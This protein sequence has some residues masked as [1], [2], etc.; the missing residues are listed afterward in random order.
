MKTSLKSFTPTK[1]PAHRTRSFT[2]HGPGERGRQTQARK[3]FTL[4]ELLVVV[5]IVSILA[6]MLLPA[7]TKVRELGRRTVC[8]HKLKQIG[9]A[10]HLYANDHDDWINPGNMI[11]PQYWDGVRSD[12]NWHERFARIG[13]FS[14]LD[15]K[16]TYTQDIAGRV[17]FLCPSEK[18]VFTYH[19][20]ANNLWVT[21]YESFSSTF[22]L[23]KFS[24][25]TAN[26]TDVILVTEGER[27]GQVSATAVSLGHV[28]FRHNGLANTLYAD[29][30]VVVKK[31]IEIT[32][33]D[34]QVGK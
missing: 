17:S 7:L 26:P 27:T 4:I 1:R 25:L 31:Q 18:R 5:A 29:G 33:A 11:G 3:G 28:A 15:Y 30:R 22:P 9:L 8:M 32:D 13:P 34:L 19:H 12:R 21:G 16:L 20:Y 14:P 6:A 23:Y 10:F 24:G 2:R